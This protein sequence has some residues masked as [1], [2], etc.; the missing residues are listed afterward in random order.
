MEHLLNDDEDIF[1]ESDTDV[2]DIE[3]EL[4]I[5]IDEEYDSDAS[6]SL[7][8]N[9]D[10]ILPLENV[11][12]EIQSE[13]VSFLSKDKS[14]RWQTH[15][16]PEANS[17]LRK[18]QILKN[19]PGPTRKATSL[20]TDIKSSFELFMSNGIKNIVIEM[21]NIKGSQIFETDWKP[22]DIIEFDAYLGL[23]IMAGVMKSHGESL[24]NLWDE[25]NGRPIFRATM[26]LKRFMAISA[27]LRFDNSVDRTERRQRDKLAPIR[28]VWD[29]W[30]NQLRVFYNPHDNCTIDEQLVPFRGRCNFKQYIPSKPA[31]YGLKI[32]ALCDSTTKY[33]WNMEVYCGRARNAQPEKNQGMYSYFILS[34]IW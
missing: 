14:V 9:A 8:F 15:P 16:P 5:N 27:S 20:V 22:M 29:K 10:D 12:N 34:Y 21:T 26:S 19:K 32:W 25:K 1:G 30:N 24:G 3:E 28:N 7:C 13:S 33:A 2:D 31:K 4:H 17:R 23:L 11:S 18:C 6:S